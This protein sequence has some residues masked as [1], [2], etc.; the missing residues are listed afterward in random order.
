MLT[1]SAPEMSRHCIVLSTDEA[2]YCAVLP[3]MTAEESVFFYTQS[4]Q[5]VLFAFA[6]PQ[7]DKDLTNI[8]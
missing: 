1:F 3:V 6:L 4:T 7:P 2:E 5:L 8:E